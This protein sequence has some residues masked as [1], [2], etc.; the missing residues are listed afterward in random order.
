MSKHLVGPRWRC[1]PCAPPPRALGGT[2]PP[3]RA[4][5]ARYA[6]G[7]YIRSTPCATSMRVR[8]FPFSL[9]RHVSLS[10]SFSLLLVHLWVHVSLASRSLSRLAFSIG[11]SLSARL[12]LLFSSALDVFK[13]C[14]FYC[15]LC[16]NFI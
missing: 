15:R 4:P 10:F 3:P 5:P 1:P 13:L 16:R 14:N 11:S 7:C 12:P 6:P 2:C 9:F 8:V